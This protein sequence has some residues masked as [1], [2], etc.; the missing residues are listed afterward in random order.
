MGI[1][2][3]DTALPR[4]RPPFAAD[5]RRSWLSVALTFERPCVHD[6]PSLSPRGD[7]S[8]QSTKSISFPCTKLLSNGRLHG[9]ITSAGSGY[10]GYDW[11]SLSRWQADPVADGLGYFI[12]LRDLDSGEVWSVTTRPTGR[13]TEHEHTFGG[14]GVFGVIAF[15]HGIE[16]TL[17]A[18]VCPDRDLELRQ[19]R[20]SNH[21]SQRRRIEVTSYVEVVL[22]H[23]AADAAHPAFSKLFVQTDQQ[24][25]GA[26]LLAH[27]RPRGAGEAGPWLM[28]AV[29]GGV[30]GQWETDRARFIGRGNG[31]ELPAALQGGQRLSGTVGNVLDPVFALR[32]TLDLPAGVTAELVF[33]LGVG[34]SREQA[35]QLRECVDDGAKV[36]SAFTKAEKKE[37][38]LYQQL[39]ITE[40]QAD[41]Y[42]A[43]LA[44]MCYGFTELRAPAEFLAEAQATPSAFERQ[45]IPPWGLHA[46]IWADHAGDDRVQELVNARRYWQAKGFNVALIIFSEESAWQQAPGESVFVRS[47]AD[48]PRSDFAGI[49]SIAR[50]VVRDRLPAM[51][52]LESRLALSDARILPRPV[53]A[54]CPGSCD[55][56][57]RALRFF[58]GYGGFSQDGREYVVDLRD[59]DSCRLK[60]PPMPWINTIA[61][62]RFGFLVSETGSGYTW[63]RNS[64]E[65]RLTHWA[66][67][68]V[69]DPHGEACYVRDEDSAEFWSPT[70]GPA[71]A[72]NDYQACHGFGYSRFIHH[73]HGLGQETTVFVPRHDSVKILCLRLT[74]N[75]DR[76]RRLSLWSFQQLVLGNSP[77]DHGRHV[78]TEFTDGVLFA[79]S[80][81]ASEFSG[82]VA[83]ATVVGGGAPTQGSGDAAAFL[84]RAGT[85]A[86][87]AALHQP[88]LNGRFGAGLDACAALRTEIAIAPW[89][90]A[91]I[92]FLLGDA[93]GRARAFDLV[94]RYGAA[95]AIAE[96]LGEVRAFWSDT[97]DAVQV[98]TPSA[99]LDLMVNGWLAYQNLSCRIWGRSAFYQSGGA[100]GYRDQLQDA[101]ALVYARPDLT[102]RQILLHAGHQFQEGDVLHWWHPDP[103]ERGLRTRFSDDLVWLPYL[104]A[105]Y[106]R[107]TGDYGLLEETAPYVT[108]RQLEP[109]EDESYLTPSRAGFVGDVYDHCC[110]AL[111]RSL[112]TGAHGLPLMGTGD[113]NDGMSRVGREGRGES[114]WMG[115][116]LYRAITDFLPLCDRRGD[117]AR[118]ARYR[119]YRDSLQ[120]ALE[121]AGWDGE[122][123]R[124][125]YYDNG[126][127]MGSKDSDECRIDA[128]VQAW[129]VISGAAPAER[130][131][132]ALDALERHLVDEGA[133]IVKLLTPPFADTPND[134]GYIKGY[135]AGVRE[136]GG[137][138]TH[139]ACWVV[140]AMAESG[141]SDRALR[142]FE[143]IGPVHHG[144][145][146]AVTDIYKVEPYVVAADIYGEPPHEG[147]GGWTWYT[148]SAGW[149]Y[150]VAL[151]SILGVTYENGDTLVVAPSVPSDWREYR[152]DLRLDD[153]RT[154]YEVLVINP[155]GS[156]NY[157][158]E[159]TLDGFGVSCSGGRARIPLARDGGVHQVQV[160]LGCPSQ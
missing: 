143:M 112:T 110:R 87:P 129:S 40:A 84:G 65:Y 20:L 21:S 113:W 64:R 81:Y 120:Q 1:I 130:C 144:Q 4:S 33:G 63:S 73:S 46:V 67:D 61:N 30:D 156:A 11:L 32:R 8:M 85:L 89:D 78:V 15:C 82:A 131:D 95:D 134:P 49:V 124:R 76:H 7:E 107:T 53:S 12:Y 77:V 50:L 99:A 72:G 68:P 51:A 148:G 28:H 34:D 93:D 125:A 132:S 31:L 126:A 58:N 114:V 83:F 86:N 117:G 69:L 116:F 37:R 59:A 141:R 24:H 94:R 97:L 43:L 121:K 139:A 155:A 66:N 140:R 102:R 105:F 70:P 60:L 115:F 27:R 90:D 44:G 135:V 127:V 80:Q 96:A 79:R 13:T 133:G 91:E 158:I 55:P 74:N 123:Y 103:I 6:P 47:G 153:R 98:Q 118:S 146:Q 106:V 142:L 128:L 18:T 29:A 88:G 62:E 138:Y 38:A 5:P 56:A 16:A 149:M 22:N 122:W 14:P 23:P 154:R 26:T 159:A 9:L 45:G 36:R 137:Q 35:L 109:G 48:M 3:L 39:G 10:C 52:E 17:R 25:Q 111:D 42:Q 71:P 75:T 19:L 157:A 41:Y 100:Y 57:S 92:Y 101:A 145:D 104:T 152:V 160:L 54:E 150:R 136:N 151:E 108:A 119:E 147:R 2:A